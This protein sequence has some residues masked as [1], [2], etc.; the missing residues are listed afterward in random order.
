MYDAK[1]DDCVLTRSTSLQPSANHSRQ[2]G[3]GPSQYSL[4]TMEQYEIVDITDIA[5]PM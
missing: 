3:Q 5:A 1:L 4:V 2:A